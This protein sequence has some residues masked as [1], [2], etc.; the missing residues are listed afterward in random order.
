MG[1]ETIR[2]YEREGLLAQPRKPVQGYRRYGETHLERVLFIKQ[3]QSFG[4]SLADAGQLIEM[5][6]RDE[7]SCAEACELARRK[8]GELR[9]RI[10]EYEALAARLTG[11]L[12]RPCVT[13]D[14]HGCGL[15]AEL[16]N[17]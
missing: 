13:G 12:E 1:T 9:K 4:F 5:L 15:I 10:A 3:C 7:A 8:I 16:R 14:K 2:F 11:L 17:V 6:E